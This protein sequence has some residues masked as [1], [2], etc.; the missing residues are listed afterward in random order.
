M[1][2]AVLLEKIVAA[3]P[4]D[5]RKTAVIARDARIYLERAE[6]DVVEAA[7]AVAV[8]SGALKEEKLKRQEELKEILEA[9]QKWARQSAADALDAETR[10]QRFNECP[11]RWS[12]R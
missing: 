2:A 3:A 8:A 6:E 7:K 9:R 1:Q 11:G 5:I 10:V 4:E 12:R